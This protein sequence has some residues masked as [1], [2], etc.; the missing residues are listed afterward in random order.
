MLDSFV[1]GCVYGGGGDISEG[2]QKA[3]N[4]KFI[5]LMMVFSLHSHFGMI[6]TF[7]VKLKPK[8]EMLLSK[9]TFSVVLYYT[10][11]KLYFITVNDEIP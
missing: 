7:I 10:S 3:K 5:A 6:S 4:Q 2:R 11:M 9:N 8:D 1:N